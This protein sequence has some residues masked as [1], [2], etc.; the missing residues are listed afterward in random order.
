[1][2]DD[3]VGLGADHVACRRIELQVD[4]GDEGAELVA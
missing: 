3:V 2:D 4:R 1:M